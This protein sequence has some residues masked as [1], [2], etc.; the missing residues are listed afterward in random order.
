M[1]NNTILEKG[2]NTL[3]LLN[4]GWHLNGYY[5]HTKSEEIATKSATS[6]LN[7]GPCSWSVM[8][9]K[10]DAGNV[11]E[12]EGL[13]ERWFL[14]EKDTG[15]YTLSEAQIRLFLTEWKILASGYV[16]TTTYKDTDYIL[17][18]APSGW[19]LSHAGEGKPSFKEYRAD[20]PQEEVKTLAAE[21]LRSI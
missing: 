21:Y 17:Y 1:W 20:R 18:W 16:L 3:R 5:F 19:K 7:L 2:K 15:L 14:N 8:E 13:N 9:S 6:V 11:L 12:R 10:D 4:K